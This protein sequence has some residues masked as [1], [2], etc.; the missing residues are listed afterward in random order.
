MRQSGREGAGRTGAGGG[1]LGYADGVGVGV[2]VGVEEGWGGGGDVLGGKGG[3]GGGGSVEGEGEG[4]GI[5]KQQQ[6]GCES[7][8]YEGKDEDE[9]KTH[10]FFFLRLLF[11]VMQEPLLRT[12]ENAGKGVFTWEEQGGSL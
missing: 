12:R 6:R 11:L 8:R 10:D 5:E 9:V 2:G 7:V 3:G 1:G 4:G